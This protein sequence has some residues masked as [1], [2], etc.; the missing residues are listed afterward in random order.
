MRPRFSDP[1]QLSHHDSIFSGV[2]EAVQM[3]VART[4]NVKINR[5]RTKDTRPR[6][7]N[8]GNGRG[9]LWRTQ[10]ARGGRVQKTLTQLFLCE[11]VVCAKTMSYVMIR[12]ACRAE[13]HDNSHVSARQLRPR[14]SFARCHPS[15]RLARRDSHEHSIHTLHQRCHLSW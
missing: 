15:P 3:W 10:Y 5:N 1:Q 6:R 2:K 9:S 8:P 13:N 7:Q 12:N 11:R 14:A 4:E